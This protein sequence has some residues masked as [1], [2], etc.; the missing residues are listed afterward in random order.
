MSKQF[1]WNSEKKD[2]ELV[3][4]TDGF[5]EEVR[6]LFG[7]EYADF[8]DKELGNDNNA[9]GNISDFDTDV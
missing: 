1:V 8:L 5:V 4:V 2:F 3:D 9:S 6:R 7:D